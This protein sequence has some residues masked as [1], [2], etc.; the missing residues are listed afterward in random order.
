MLNFNYLRSSILAL[1]LLSSSFGDVLS[2]HHHPVFSQ[3]FVRYIKARAK[4]PRQR[5]ILARVLNLDVTVDDGKEIVSRIPFLTGREKLELLR[6]IDVH[7]ANQIQRIIT[8][9]EK[10]QPGYVL[11]GEEREKKLAL[12]KFVL[13]KVKTEAQYSTVQQVFEQEDTALSTYIALKKLSLLNESELELARKISHGKLEAYFN[14]ERDKTHRYGYEIELSSVTTN[15]FDLDLSRRE[16]NYG[17]SRHHLQSAGHF[18]GQEYLA[19]VIVE[20]GDTSLRPEGDVQLEH[21]RIEFQGKDSRFV[22]GDQR[23]GIS[24]LTLNREM[25]ALGYTHLFESTIPYEIQ[26][27][28]GASPQYQQGFSS[29]EEEPVYLYGL[30]YRKIHS[31]EREWSLSYLY[32]RESEGSSR[33]HSEQLGLRHIAK[34]SRYWDMEA[35]FA[36]SFGDR[37]RGNYEHGFAAF[38]KLYHKSDRYEGRLIA[39][40]YDSG[41]FSLT[42]E[43]FENHYLFD[44]QFKQY[45]QWGAVEVYGQYLGNENNPGTV[46]AQILRPGLGVHLRSPFGWNRTV[47]D[48]QYSESREESLD[49]SYLLES[50]THWFRLSRNFTHMSLDGSVTFRES[51]DKILSPIADKE[52]SWQLSSRGYFQW[53]HNP[54]QPHVFLKSERRDYFNGRDDRRYGLG[55]ELSTRI[56]GKAQFYGGYTLWDSESLAALQD[57]TMKEGR[58]SID[59]PFSRDWERSLNLSYSYEEGELPRQ[60]SHGSAV[61]WKISYKNLF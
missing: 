53:R 41:Y 28:A 22:I 58:V 51:F 12:K 30:N 3:S 43:D 61:E 14:R 37:E 13:T 11:L 19:S 50:N 39:E 46:E 32:A 48:Y 8:S 44:G 54:L 24:S 34:L 31:P 10:G 23:P 27:F 17:R 47:A 33:R 60:L 59:Y 15:G 38:M 49:R 52:V 42:G 45:L 4:T 18:K 5:K 40:K 26:V 1:A 6:M 36:S 56:L 9:N 7:Q 20:A 2:E 35:E 16:S 21:L 57:A 25:R 55:W 29:V